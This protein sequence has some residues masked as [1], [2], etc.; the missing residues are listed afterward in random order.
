MKPINIKKFLFEMIP[1]FIENIVT[2][3]LTCNQR[4]HESEYNIIIDKNNMQ[5]YILYIIIRYIILL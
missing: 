4:N 2:K 1:N 5:I 3:N